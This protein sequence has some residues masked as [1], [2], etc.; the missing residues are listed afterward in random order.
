MYDIFDAEAIAAYSLGQRRGFM[1]GV[2][3]GA[4]LVIYAQKYTIARRRAQTPGV[5]YAAGRR[6]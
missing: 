1:V 6:F 4:A 2:L 5:N 3:C